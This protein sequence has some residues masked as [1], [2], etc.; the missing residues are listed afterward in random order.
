MQPAWLKPRGQDSA[1]ADTW[2]SPRVLSFHQEEL[3]ED[4]PVR[5][6]EEPA[7]VPVAHA[8]APWWYLDIPDLSD[9]TDDMELSVHEDSVEEE[10]E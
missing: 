1:V 5:Q 3:R 9:S 7:P 2:R 8:L 10:Q 6:P 4:E